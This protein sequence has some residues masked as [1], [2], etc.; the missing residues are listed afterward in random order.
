MQDSLDFVKD[1]LKALLHE[2]LKAKTRFNLVSFNTRVTAWRDRMVEV[3]DYSL[4]SAIN[5]IGGLTADG[6]TNTLGAIRFAL[7]DLNTEAVY[8][9]SDGRPDQD[10]RQILGQVSLSGGKIPIHTIS[11]NCTDREANLFLSQLAETTGGRYH[12]FS[13]SGFGGYES[14]DVRLL[15]EEVKR[16]YGFLEK[17]TN[18]RDE[19]IRLTNVSGQTVNIDIKS[20]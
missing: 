18:L 14:E 16:G 12:C 20:R 17:I 9:L 5:W 15:R 1:K 19:C 2:Q 10:A 8:L 3:D 7:S 4:Q 13:E 11:F 6:T